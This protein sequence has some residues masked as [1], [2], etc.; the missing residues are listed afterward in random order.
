MVGPLSDSFRSSSRRSG[1]RGKKILHS[2]LRCQWIASINQRL[3]GEPLPRL[4]SNPVI[5][6]FSQLPLRPGSLLSI[7]SIVHSSPSAVPRLSQY[8]SQQDRRWLRNT[9]K[10]KEVILL[11][12]E[13]LN[14]KHG[15]KS[16]LACRKLINIL[17]Y[18]TR[19]AP[20]YNKIVPELINCFV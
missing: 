5:S 2:S 11:A 13:T 14:A 4:D 20:L 19:R 9:H 15:V 6:L 8:Y 1:R 12:R 10:G 17:I 16:N 7:C 3:I 18:T